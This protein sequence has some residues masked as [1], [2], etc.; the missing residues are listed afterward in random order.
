MGSQGKEMSK[1]EKKMSILSIDAWRDSEGGWTWNKWFKRGS[2]SQEDY[3]LLD[4]NRKILK[5]L[6]KE[7]ILMEETAGLVAIEDDQYNTVV[8][9]KGTR[10]PLYAIAYGELH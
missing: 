7:G 8:V 6:R 4:T 3:D 5:W 9:W 1:S 2:I 10:E